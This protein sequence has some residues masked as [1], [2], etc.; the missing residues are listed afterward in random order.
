MKQELTFEERLQEANLL[1]RYSQ[2]EEACRIYSE[3]IRENSQIPELHN[4]YGLALFYLNRF[5][6]AVD[7]FRKA[8]ELDNNFALSYINIGLVYLNREEYNNA[9]TSFLKALDIDNKNPETHYNLA[10]TYYR[11]GRKPDAIEHY[12]S[13]LSYAGENYDKLKVSV[14]RIIAQIK[15]SL[16]LN[17]S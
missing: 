9:E 2:Y 8:V 11:M 6:E 3:L 17:N 13:F 14:Q 1:L 15:E 16:E 7:E 4:N 5:D 10:V 12:E